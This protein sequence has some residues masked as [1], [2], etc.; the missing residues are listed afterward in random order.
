MEIITRKEAKEKGLTHYFTGKPC[1]HGHIELRYTA[2][3]YCDE[4]RKI[5]WRQNKDKHLSNSKRW[6]QQNPDKVKKHCQTQQKRRRIITASKPLSPRQ[7]AIKEGRETYLPEKP[8]VKGHRALRKVNH[9]ACPI[10]S[11][12]RCKKYKAQNQEKIKACENEYRQKNKDKLAKARQAYHQ[13]NKER[14]R[15]K[16]TEWLNNGGRAKKCIA[17]KMRDKAIKR[18]T[19]S[20]LAN[21]DFYELYQAC[22]EISKATGIEHQVDHY[23]PIRGETVCGLNAPWNLQIITAEENWRKGNKMPEEFYGVGHTPP[24][25]YAN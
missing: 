12:E 13:A 2:T 10:C 18:A 5:K 16:R 6:K 20:T 1:K 17:Q 19:P 24:M 11:A 3:G 22:N 21:Q 23:Y 25:D 7:Q 8:C 9:P 15:E 4:C 14:I